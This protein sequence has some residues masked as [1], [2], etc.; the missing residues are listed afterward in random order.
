MHHWVWKN[1]YFFV[2]LSE[3]W[4]SW[5]EQW[6][7]VN[8]R[9][10][11]DALTALTRILRHPPFT[12][13]TIAA[14]HSLHSIKKHSE[15]LE[16]LADTFLTS[17][18]TPLYWYQPNIQYFRLSLSL[19]MKKMCCYFLPYTAEIA[20]FRK[21]WKVHRDYLVWTSLLYIVFLLL[22]SSL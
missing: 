21:G 12:L 22:F 10:P 5:G 8:V 16:Y 20:A 19:L 2:F 14:V 13:R 11:N 3:M 9:V 4:T 17:N 6:E 1:R 7:T 18:L 15:G